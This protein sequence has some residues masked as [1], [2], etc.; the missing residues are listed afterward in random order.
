MPPTEKQDAEHNLYGV[1]F[2]DLDLNLENAKL[3]DITP[4][5]LDYFEI[6]KGQFDGKSLWPRKQDN[7]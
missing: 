2:T 4:T 1:I 5:I 7:Q 6:E 3:I